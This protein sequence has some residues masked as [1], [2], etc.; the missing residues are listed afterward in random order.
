MKLTIQQLIE[1]TGEG[2]TL[3]APPLLLKEGRIRVLEISYQ[4]V[5][6]VGTSPITIAL[7]YEP[8]MKGLTLIV[9]HEGIQL[10]LIALRLTGAS[11]VLLRLRTEELIQFNLEPEKEDEEPRY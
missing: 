4:E 6:V 2:I 7:A 5:K 8:Q 9:P 11:T 1:D 10:L 3:D